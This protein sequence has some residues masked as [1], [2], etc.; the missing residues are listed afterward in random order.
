MQIH[1]ARSNTSHQHV[2]TNAATTATSFKASTQSS[3]GNVLSKAKPMCTTHNVQYAKNHQ[4]DYKHC[5][6][7]G[8]TFKGSGTT[9]AKYPKCTKK[10]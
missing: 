1:A 6:K 4:W 7:C 5:K 2:Q 3:L 8:G 9:C 10:K